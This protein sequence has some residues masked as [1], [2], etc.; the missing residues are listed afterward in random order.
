MSARPSLD[1][2]R[3]AAIRAAFPDV[4]R[5]RLAARAAHVALAVAAAAL[6][7]FSLYWLDFSF[8]RFARGVAR[9]GQFV[10]LMLP[11]NAGG[12]LSLY[13]RSLADTFAI[14]V[15]GTALGALVAAPFG[16]LA[17]KN[18]VPN[19]IFH[20]SLRRF[21]DCARS[22]DILIWALIWVGVVGLGPFAGVL[23]IASAD[24][25][26]FGK[27]FSETI[28]AAETRAIEGV[29]AAGGDRAAEIRF[30]L[31]P[32]ILPVLAGQILYFL[33]TN[34]RAAMVLGVV[35]AGGVGL[36]LSEQIRLLEW[37]RVAVLILLL[38]VSVAALD[39]L[40]EWARRRLISGEEQRL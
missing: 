13:L 21:V 11:P 27:L 32:Q 3:E 14:A 36:H 26:A 22:I 25:G 29:R 38:L 4:F 12:D 9:L 16:F 30:G 6:F 8:E 28:E 33:E 37:P 34:V 35:G 20:F 19:A 39:R 17:A 15:L 1:A 24:F 31:L 10:V 7:A 23:A 2:A 5:P 40:S 18:I